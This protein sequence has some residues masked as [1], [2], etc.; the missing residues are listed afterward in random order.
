MRL[1]YS[2]VRVRLLFACVVLWV[3]QAAAVS[4]A[5]ATYS[6]SIRRVSTGST[7]TQAARVE[8]A[9]TAQ[10]FAVTLHGATLTIERVADG[11]R[12]TIEE[13]YGGYDRASAT[14][15]LD[16]RGNILSVSA[17][18]SPAATEG[19]TPVS[20]ADIRRI[21]GLCVLAMP[22][23]TNTKTIA[24]GHSWPAHYRTATPVDSVIRRLN[25]LAAKRTKEKEGLAAQVARLEAT[26]M[27][28][29]E[30]MSKDSKRIGRF[31]FAYQ[32]ANFSHTRDILYDLD[33]R[34]VIKATA[35]MKATGD[36]QTT[37]TTMSVELAE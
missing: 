36:D 10:G 9:P 4:Q 14:V 33:A 25:D 32:A 13:A 19:R 3:G 37:T 21:V 30:I 15:K 11:Q 28:L 31:A 23:T 18:S 24:S 5:G 6:M 35:I 12:P 26:R 1:Q 27:R 2:V 17:V 34:R 7:W 16:E 22:V 8:I 29:A 20:E